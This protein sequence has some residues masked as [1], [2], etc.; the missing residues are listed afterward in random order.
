M[1]TSNQ[2]LVEAD[3]LRAGSEPGDFTGAAQSPQ[4]LLVENPPSNLDVLTGQLE[5]QGYRVLA[6]SDGGMALRIASAAGVRGL[7]SSSRITPA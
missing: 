6:A 4:V 5:P 7:S 1:G 2:H 3:P